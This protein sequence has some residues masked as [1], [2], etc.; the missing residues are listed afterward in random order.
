MGNSRLKIIKKALH[1]FIPAHFHD[2]FGLFFRL[3]HSKNPAAFF[4][5]WT[6]ALALAALPLD[7]LLEL[8]ERRFYAK[9]ANPKFPLIFV[10]GPPRSGTS[11]VAQVLIQYLPVCYPNNLTAV[12]QKSPITANRLFKKTIGNKQ[13]EYRSYYGKTTKF[14]GPNDALYLWDRW[15][16]KDRTII[17][18]SISQEKK[19]AMVKFFGAYQEAFHK[20]FLNKNNNLN[21]C[22]NLVAEIL[23][24]S[25]F[26]CLTRDPVYLAQSLLKSRMEMHGDVRSPY[27]LHDPLR[28]KNQMDYVNDV[29]E[30]VL[31]HE[32]KIREQQEKVGLQRFWIISYESF[33]E[34]P[35]KL[36]SRVSKE[37]IDQQIDETELRQHLKPFKDANTVKIDKA[38]FEKIQDTLQ[39]LKN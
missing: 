6:S 1:R 16:G 36:V 15:F 35:E 22:A 20:P 26:I 12:F 3:I 18:D 31:F 33:C 30:Q 10:A 28:K 37:I 24:N 23:N 14:S 13:I 7:M 38:L 8:S 19:T 25:Y 34:N 2:P 27:G 9:A 29:C 11:L 39:R 5:M 32:K 21:T 4:A 17:P